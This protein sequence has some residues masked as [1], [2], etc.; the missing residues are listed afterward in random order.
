MIVG[1][2]GGIASGKSTVARA[3][4]ELGAAW[5]DADDVARDIVAPGEPALERI[6]Q[7]FG[8]EMI[9]SEGQL[10]RV[11]LRQCIF[12][13]EVQRRK[14]EEITHP[15]IRERIVTRLEGFRQGGTEYALLVSPLLLETD[16][17]RLVDR[18]LVVDVDEE[19]QLART[20]QRDGIDSEQARAIIAAQLPRAQRLA[21]AHDVLD[22]SGTTQEMQARIERLDGRYRQLA[23]E[24]QPGV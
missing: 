19:T 12:S 16:Q 8:E 10:D 20:R 9:T 24:M 23:R 14:L 5:V 2:T 7:Q 15:L 11:R 13:E 4:A 18:I 1:L 21:A 6:R 22:N 17:Y 3:F